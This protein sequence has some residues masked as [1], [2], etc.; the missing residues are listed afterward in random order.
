ME[1]RYFVKRRNENDKNKLFNEKQQKNAKKVFDNI[2]NI[3]YCEHATLTRDVTCSKLWR[4]GG[5]ISDKKLSVEHT[6][7]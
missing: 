1:S 7:S 6:L 3:L 5:N 4:Y 2:R